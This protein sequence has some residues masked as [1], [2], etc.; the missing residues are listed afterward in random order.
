MHAEGFPPLARRF[1][2]QNMKFQINGFREDL[3][4]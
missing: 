4:P 2:R 3:L 1:Q